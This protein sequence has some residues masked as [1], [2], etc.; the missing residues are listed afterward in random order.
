M[1]EAVSTVIK[2]KLQTMYHGCLNRCLGAS[3]SFCD[4]EDRGLVLEQYHRGLRHRWAGWHMAPYYA[5]VQTSITDHRPAP[6]HRG[7][8]G[9]R[10][11]NWL[12]Q[13]RQRYF[14]YSS[15]NVEPDNG[16]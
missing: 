1:A 8:S 11:W 16:Q 2:E 6:Q 13:R 4:Q 14:S 15:H 5:R 10:D 9:G 7:Q 12:H 3:M